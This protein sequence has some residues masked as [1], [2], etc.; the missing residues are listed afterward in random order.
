MA[1][2]N[3][4][5]D[6]GIDDS[7][8]LANSRRLRAEVVARHRAIEKLRASGDDAAADELQAELGDVKDPESLRGQ[9]LEAL[10]K[11]YGAIDE[12][13]GI[14][15]T[16]L[17]DSTGMTGGKGAGLIN[18]PLSLWNRGLN[19]VGLESNQKLAD[20]LD[21]RKGIS[22]DPAEGVLSGLSETAAMSGP[23]GLAEKALMVGSRAAPF[24]S[25]IAANP[26]TRAGVQGGTMGAIEADP[27]SKLSGAGIGATAGMLGAGALGMAGDAGHAAV[28]GLQAAPEAAELMKELP[29][30]TLTWG[31]M[32]PQGMGNKA[33]QSAI[34]RWLSQKA[35][36]QANRRLNLVAANRA[37]VPSYDDGTLAAMSDSDFQALADRI[38]GGERGSLTMPAP[39]V[40]QPL[41]NQLASE[42]HET[43]SALYK[44]AVDPFA[45]GAYIMPANGSNILLK[46]AFSKL[47][48]RVP[49]AAQAAN[50]E[51]F[52]RDNLAARIKQ[53]RAS[54]RG[55]TA[56][57]LKALYSDIHKE[58][59]SLQSQK[60]LTTTDRAVIRT[61]G[62]AKDLV[63]QALESQLP[64]GANALRKAA[65]SVYGTNMVLQEATN[66]TKG[67]RGVLSPSKLEDEAARAT[68]QRAG[69]SAQA[70]ASDVT[71][72]WDAQGNP[73]PGSGERDLGR[74]WG[75]IE[76]KDPQMQTGAQNAMATALEEVGKLP[77]ALLSAPAPILSA[78]RA[79]RRFL[80]G[81]TKPQ[82]SLQQIFANGRTQLGGVPMPVTWNPTL[83]YLKHIAGDVLKIA[84]AAALLRT[85][86]T[87]PFTDTEVGGESTGDFDPSQGL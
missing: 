51:T 64:P 84:P 11:E 38:K 56:G 25:R 27:G 41:R 16:R 1:A 10:S 49:D 46:D 50:V 78:S 43:L 42:S 73:I 85:G 36:D 80:Q 66:K 83:A 31:Q 34:W 70:A 68:R 35:R 58:M 4:Y 5:A 13:R 47:A 81:V 52:L 2:S 86:A 24:L 57:D 20:W 54:G 30:G 26:I 75:V 79:G 44:N 67:V 23:A 39:D 12:Q 53:A 17:S 9:L 7:Q 21:E 48:K 63:D 28:H 71:R 29:D 19:T 69:K 37:A 33:E 40:N 59:S 8:W 14:T 18:G 3:T 6:T 76:E 15:K 65:D 87:L 74:N 62:K 72:K 22:E 55:L 77:A 82:R 60:T 61:Y 32:R 45:V